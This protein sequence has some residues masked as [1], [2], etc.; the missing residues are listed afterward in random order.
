MRSFSFASQLAPMIERYLAVRKDEGYLSNNHIYYLQE[1]DLLSLSDL[2]KPF[3]TKELVEKWD[4]A[5]PYLTNS[6][7]IQRHN[8]IRKFAAFSFA[9]DG[10]S[11]VPDTSKLRHNSIYS[12]HIFT[13]EEISCLIKAADNLPVRKNAPTRHLVVPAVIRLLYSS[14]LRINEAL[15]LKMRDVDLDSGVITVYNGKGGKDRTVPV[16]SSVVDYLKM[17]SGQLANDRE[18]FF[19]SSYDHYSSNTIYTIFRELLFLCNIPHT[20]NGPRVHDF[21]HT[22]AVHSLEKQLSEGYDPMV[23][24]PRLAAYLGHKSYKETS[25]YIHLTISS[26][27]DLTQKLDSAF[28]GIIPIAGGELLEE[29]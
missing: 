29:N 24:L 16:H 1:L 13:Y 26:F 27:P 7:K 15:R 6:T 22:F 25:W 8:T 18:W 3:I 14:G 12:P 9:Q 20:G 11:Y 17:Y 21:R 4:N 23:I 10:I 2:D 5:K 28:S 19:P